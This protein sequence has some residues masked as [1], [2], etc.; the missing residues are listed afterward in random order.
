VLRAMLSL[1]NEDRHIPVFGSFVSAAQRAR[2]P[3]G[4]A[5]TDKLD[6]LNYGNF[7][8][9]LKNLIFMLH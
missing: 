1:Q 8:C 9:S 3:H 2:R 4:A 7:L 5:D 6:F